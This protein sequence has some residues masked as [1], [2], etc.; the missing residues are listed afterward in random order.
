MTVMSLAALVAFVPAMSGVVD[1]TARIEGVDSP[2]VRVMIRTVDDG[3][4]LWVRRYQLGT[5]TDV[6]PGTRKINV[7]CEFRATWGSRL[8][9][10]D[11]T[12][13]AEA[14]KTYR[15]NARPDGENCEVT[16]EGPV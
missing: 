3:E 2:G 15:L 11:V 8:T 9:P 5:T 16:V 12:V 14:G 10:G 7:I 6:P 13:E 1:P 4:I